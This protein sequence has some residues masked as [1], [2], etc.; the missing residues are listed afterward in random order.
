MEIRRVN[1]AANTTCQK[2]EYSASPFAKSVETVSKTSIG[3]APKHYAQ[4]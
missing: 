2:C 1:T 3:K 4:S